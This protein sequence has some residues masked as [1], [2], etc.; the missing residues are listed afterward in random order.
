MFSSAGFSSSFISL[1]LDIWLGEFNFSLLSKVCLGI[2]NTD[3][4]ELP[5][6]ATFD[7]IKHDELVVRGFL[8]RRKFQVRSSPSPC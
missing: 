8:G 5:I 6:I 2:V 7:K 3:V 4:V 1:V